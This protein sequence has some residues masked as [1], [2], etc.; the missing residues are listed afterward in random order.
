M[1]TENATAAAETSTAA[2]E[3]S[4]PSAADVG[5]TELGALD[6]AV[7]SAAALRA[8]NE[9]LRA[10]LAA[11]RPPT[12][13]NAGRGR[14]W[15][16]ALVVLLACLGIALSALVTWAHRA[17]LSTD[18]WVN[19]VGPVIED[20][21]VVTAISDYGAGQLVIAMDV[22][23]RASE[24]LPPNLRLLSLPLTIAARQFTAEVL[25]RVLSQP[26]FQE[27]WIGSQRLLHQTAL[28]VLRG[29]VDSVQIYPDGSVSLNLFP[30][31]DQALAQI[32]DQAQDLLGRDVDLPDL[33]A[34]DPAAAR[35]QLSLALGVDL[36][37]G[38]GEVEVA[39]SDELLKLQ[40]FVRVFDAVAFLLPLAS[41]ALLA[42]GIWL[43][44]DRRRTVLQ[45]GA[46]IVIA[47]IVVWALMRWAGGQAE[48]A[49]PVGAGGVFAAAVLDTA[50]GNL[51]RW[52]AFLGLVGVG[53]AF[54]A[55]AAGRPP[56]LVNAWARLQAT[57]GDGQTP[58]RNETE[59]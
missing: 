17:V 50:L 56:R 12:T 32:E 14:R 59:A 21:E 43:S 10:E 11:A 33:P 55:Y 35:R 51:T 38:F 23:A 24:A 13:A 19:T 58:E 8:E 36:P 44:R 20:P 30:L 31:M 34:D 41:L 40:R 37:A 28:K 22:Q 4:T 53:V 7:E 54:G 1:S 57:V 26:K 25:S 29:E 6:S 45:L 46:G 48:A 39:Q 18:G 15:A 49:L 3:T 9:R 52:L 16:V 27:L 47:M 5:A 42:L 2:A